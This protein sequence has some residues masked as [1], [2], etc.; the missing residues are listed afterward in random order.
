MRSCR[1]LDLLEGGV[2]KI[3][4]WV[5]YGCEGKRRGKKNISLCSNFNRVCGLSFFLG[6]ILGY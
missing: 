2:D 6:D 4:W 5:R 1:I 3:C